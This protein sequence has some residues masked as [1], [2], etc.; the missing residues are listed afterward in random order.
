[1]SVHQDGRL[2]P[3]PALALARKFAIECGDDN[4]TP[5]FYVTDFDKSAWLEAG[6]E[7]IKRIWLDE[8][9]KRAYVICQQRRQ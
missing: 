5:R 7:W 6:V 1:M 2:P 4:G 8:A 3:A 9:T